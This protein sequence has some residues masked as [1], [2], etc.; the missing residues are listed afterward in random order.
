MF[1]TQ[2]ETIEWAGRTLTLE[3]GKVA[4]QA[5]GSVMATYGET[6]VL[7]TVVS[8]KEPK[9]GFDFFPLTVNYQ[10]KYFAAGRI[11]GGYFKRE[12][13]PT[14]KETLTSRLIDRPIRP[15]F[16]KGYKNDTQVILTVLQHDLEN[17]S[18]VVAMV[19]ASAALTLSGVPFMGP[20]GGARVGYIDGEFVL[21]PALDQMDESDLDLVVAGT[22]DAVLMVESEAKELSEEQMLKAVMFGH[23]GFQPVIDA[24]IKL[25]EKAAKEPRDHAVE[26]LSAI[27]AKARE[28]CEADMRAAY[29]IKEKTAR[30]DAVD[31]AKRK[32]KEHFFPDSEAIEGAP[33]SNQLGGVLKELEA[34]IVRWSILDEKTRIDGRGLADVR[35]IVAEA[36]VLPRTHGSALFTRGETQAIVVATLGTG[37]DEQFI[38]S[39]EGTYKEHFLLHY[40]FPPYSVGETGRMGGAGRREIGHGKLAWRAVHPVLP[41]KDEFPYTIRVVSEI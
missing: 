13:R 35:P 38:D 2:T 28:L 33:T 29:Q 24:I 21:N 23:A 9:P 34:S 40:N 25:A 39:L 16:A 3:T 10:E 32:V 41:A 11:P 15:L 26:D 1:D 19:A 31:A 36:G 6:V 37:E 27:E 17:D 30:R 22:G 12:G 8:E 5:D 14:E 18:D 20:I 4:R 7:A